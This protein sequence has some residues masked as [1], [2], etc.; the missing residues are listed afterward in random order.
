MLVFKLK[1]VKIREKFQNM[2]FNYFLIFIY[3]LELFFYI[4]LVSVCF[5]NAVKLCNVKIR[6]LL[7][8]E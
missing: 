5:Y 3:F 4:L 7:Y 8:K 2:K 6:M 1:I